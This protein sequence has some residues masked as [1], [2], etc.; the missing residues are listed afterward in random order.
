MAPALVL[1]DGG[2]AFRHVCDRGDRG[3]YV[4]AIPLHPQHVVDPSGDN[5]TPSILC[6]DC[7]M[8]GYW[9]DGQWRPC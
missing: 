7:G 9:T 2:W 1:R 8:H 5:V 6:P 3:M 4:V